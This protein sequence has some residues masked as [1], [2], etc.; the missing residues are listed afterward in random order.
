MFSMAEKFR[1]KY[2]IKSARL[3]SWDYSSD[4]GYFITICTHHRKSVFGHI[5]QG[6]MCLSDAGK[7]V[8]QCWFDLPNHYPNLQLDTF[9]IMPNHIHGIMIINN[10]GLGGKRHGIPEFVRALKSFSS[11]RINEMG[12]GGVV[13][14]TGL[15]PVSTEPTN[16]QTNNQSF[17]WQSR[18]YDHIIRT[19]DEHIRIS[20]YIRN[21]PMNW[22]ND[23][24]N[25]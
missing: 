5:N 2:L 19:H 21:N 22:E 25:G 8:E 10:N 6:I 1:N 16:S 7:I 13:V 4:G 9:V 15:R 17:I 12:N 14:E 18:Y 23:K 24:L 3:Q 20:N 11:R